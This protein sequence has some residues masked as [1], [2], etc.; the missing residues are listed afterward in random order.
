MHLIWFAKAA[1]AKS[2][3]GF[4]KQ[5]QAKSKYGLSHAAQGEDVLKEELPQ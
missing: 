3:Y 1:Q 2:K 5:L 4:A